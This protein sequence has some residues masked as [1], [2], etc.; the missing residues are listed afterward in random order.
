MSQRWLLQDC[1][2]TPFNI[3]NRGKLR[4]GMCTCW[5]TETSGW[6]PNLISN[7]D[8]PCLDPNL[9][10]LLQGCNGAVCFCDDRDGCNSQIRWSNKSVRCHLIIKKH[11]PFQWFPPDL[12]QLYNFI[13]NLFSGTAQHCV[14]FSSFAFLSHLTFSFI[15]LRYDR[16]IMDGAMHV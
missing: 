13:D 8:S 12:M 9:T 5:R 7:R 11:V 16:I 15:I 3:K 6:N 4:R 14:S 2:S 10:L 1:Y